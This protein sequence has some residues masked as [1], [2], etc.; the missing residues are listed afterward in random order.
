MKSLTSVVFALLVFCI[1]CKENPIEVIKEKK[2]G[3]Q[4]EYQFDK[5]KKVK[6]GYF[7]SFD[8]KGRLFMETSYVNDTLE[9]KEI[10]YYEN[11]KKKS[12]AILKKGLYDGP[13]MSWYENGSKEQEYNY[14]MSQ[15]E[16]SLKTYYSNGKLKEDVTMKETLENGPFVEYYENGNLKTKGQYASGPNSE[17]CYLYMY[18]SLQANE[19][20]KKMICNLG[21][22]CTVWEKDSKIS[23]TPECKKRVEEL[24]DKCKDEQ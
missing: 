23:I 16:G 13:Y 5:N 12:E 19:L 6:N 8:E 11:G 10:F 20:T 22:C 2:D 7:K 21:A 24:K 1:S 3:K 17:Q 15:I 4:V 18:D 14:V 9:G